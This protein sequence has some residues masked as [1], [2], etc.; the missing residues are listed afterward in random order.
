MPT[1]DIRFS[2]D[3]R[4][5][6]QDECVIE[7]TSDKEFLQ[8]ECEAI[9][10]ENWELIDG[11][12]NVTLCSGVKLMEIKNNSEIFI[13]RKSDPSGH[14]R[15]FSMFPAFPNPF[16]STT[17]LRYFLPQDAFV[18]LTV[19]DIFG[20]KIIQLINTNQ[21]GGFKSV[22]W[23]AT[24]QHGRSVSAGIYFYRIRTDS[25]VQTKKMI[26]LN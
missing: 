1:T 13:L 23:D 21:L 6:S 4:V 14:P 15:T 26:L 19:F 17:T 7:I 2:G 16:N 5:C 3:T 8:F 11:T 24:D 22:Q 10:G 12:E 9:D 25:F 18:S 20:K